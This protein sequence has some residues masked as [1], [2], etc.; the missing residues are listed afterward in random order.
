[1]IPDAALLQAVVSG[2]IAGAAAGLASTAVWLVALVRRPGLATRLPL[3]GHLTIFGIVF[4]NAFVISLTLVG[5]VLGALQHRFGGGP[6]GAFSLAVLAG[7]V[8]IA[9]AYAFVRGGIRGEASPY[10]LLTLAVIAASF[11][12]LLPWLAEMDT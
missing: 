8:A 7:A 2:W 1:M 5:L 10:V 9:A 12:V 6:G 3:H 11:A 4:A